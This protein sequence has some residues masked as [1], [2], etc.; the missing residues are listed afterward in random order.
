MSFIGPNNDVTIRSQIAIII[1]RKK[2]KTIVK[3]LIKKSLFLHINITNNNTL[4]FI[5]F[6]LLCLRMVI[7]ATSLDDEINNW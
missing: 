5:A 2:N 1:H 4:K 7:I 6:V 3:F